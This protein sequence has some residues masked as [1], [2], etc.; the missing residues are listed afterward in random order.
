M[1][2]T[3]K[4]F[5]EPSLATPLL[6]MFVDLYGLAPLVGNDD[7]RWN[8]QTVEMEMAAISGGVLPQNLDKIMALA[9]VLGTDHFEQFCPDFIRICNVLAD[10]PTDGSFDPAEVHEIAWA[11]IETGLLLGRRPKF[12]PEI[13]GYIE[14][15]LKDEGFNTVPS[16]LDVVLPDKDASWET[17]NQNTEDPDLFEMTQDASTGREAE[18]QEYLK[19]RLGRMIQTLHQLPLSQREAN[20]I[21]NI[22]QELKALLTNEDQSTSSK[23]AQTR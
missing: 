16:P 6:L 23:M 7:E 8:P 14:K 9:E 1:P 13:T 5:N 18:L 12:N 19:Q 20:W 4:L 10:S 11:V 17:T 2:Q 21:E 22:N 3:T 15:A